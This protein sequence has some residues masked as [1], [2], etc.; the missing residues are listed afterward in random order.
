MVRLLIYDIEDGEL[1]NA[2]H[3]FFTNVLPTRHRARELPRRLT[4]V[5]PFQRNQLGVSL[6]DIPRGR[7]VIDSPS[8][9][10]HIPPNWL[11]LLG[12]VK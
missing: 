12:S 8:M 5:P 1:Q 10:T 2:R 9:G 11:S 4:D 3:I 7:S 6:M